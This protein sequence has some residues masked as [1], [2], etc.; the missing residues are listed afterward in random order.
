[1]VAKDF[2][3]ADRDQ[4]FLLPPDMRDWLSQ[5]HLVWFLLDVVEALDMSGFEATARLGG[6][7]RRAYD[8][9]TLLGVLL[10]GY[11]NAQH[12][13]RQLERLCEVDVAMRVMAGNEVPDHTT[14]SRFRQQHEKALEELFSQVLVMCA[15]AGMGRL[16]VIAID[17]TKIAADASRQA[18]AGEQA[19]R[20]KA[21][22][23]LAQAAAVDAAEDAEYGDSRGDE[24]PPSW[25]GRDGRKE[26]VKAA[27]ADLEAEKTRAAAERQ[28]TDAQAALRAAEYLRKAT[29]P[30]L[31]PAQRHVIG[32]PPPG[33]NKV[34]IAQARLDRQVALAEQRRRDRAAREG[35]LAA[36]GRKLPGPAAAAVTEHGH[37]R[38]AQRQL[39]AA[40]AQAAAQAAAPV[41][42]QGAAPAAKAASGK[43][44]VRN[45]TDPDSR[46]MPTSQGGWVQ[47]YNAQLGVTDDQIIIALDLVQTSFDG[48][49]FIPMMVRARDAADLI[50]RSRN[51]PVEGE[52]IGT[53]VADA[54][55]L[56][57]ENLTA[58]GPDRLIAL[59]KTRQQ[60]R[61]ARKH[62]AHGDPP[63]DATPQQRMDHRLRTPEG[64]ALYKR[65]GVTVEPVN[66]HLKDRIGLRRFSRRGLPA[67]RSELHLAAT[68]A[69]LI[70]LYR[71]QPATA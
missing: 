71:A 36:Q 28:Q 54:G 52:G 50:A 61:Q 12:S 4:V 59:G 17:G 69:N 56:S 29:D 14:L 6:A 18:N 37:V 58:E 39:D 11:A 22:A 10:Y 8:P 15:K 70:K 60:A 66:G 27:L 30:D 44:R 21:A 38:R 35:P 65:R 45:T 5:D 19:L 9:C 63:P 43:A 23:M 13:S 25:S 33:T 48:H 67:A 7:G 57:T 62:P 46:L 32:S 51:Q 53:I 68:V 64:A 1:L 31:T 47:G 2:R 41:A 55:Y 24:L 49:Q 16:G 40:L 34:A 42:R 3:R 20:D 26:R